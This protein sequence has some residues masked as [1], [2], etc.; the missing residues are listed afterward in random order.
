MNIAILHPSRGRPEKAFTTMMQ[1]YKDAGL[2]ETLIEYHLS[3]DSDDP[4][5]NDY[6]NLFITQ[7]KRVRVTVRPNKSVVEATNVVA[8]LSANDVL[9]YCSDDFEAPELWLKRLQRIVDDMT[10]PKS[11]WVIKP[12]DALQKFSKGI[13]TL[14]IMSRAAYKQLGYFWHPGY[15]SMY[16][17]EDLYWTAKYAEMLILRPDL[18]FVHHHYTNKRSLYDGTYARTESGEFHHIG[19]TLFEKRKLQNFPL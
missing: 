14:P 17:D 1:W 18:R 6:L 7:A 15:A 12:D 16:V 11:N 3:L 19:K 9:I 5:L 13:I 10:R 8:A 2:P 4:F